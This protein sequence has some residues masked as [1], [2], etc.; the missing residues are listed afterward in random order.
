M[1]KLLVMLSILLAI[2]CK[3]EPKEAVGPPIGQ[4]PTS[5]NG[6]SK[7]V[8]PPEEW[9]RKHYEENLR[10]VSDTGRV[11]F[12]LN[13]RRA[14]HPGILLRVENFPIY[15]E[16]TLFH[17]EQYAVSKVYLDDVNDYASSER[18]YLFEQRNYKISAEELE[19]L[20]ALANELN[21]WE[22]KSDREEI[23]DGSNWEL[24]ILMNGKYH[25]VTSNSVNPAIK[26]IGKEMMALARLNLPKEEIY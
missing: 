22:E 17:V 5:E 4:S 15:I 26:R 14:H 21:I 7:D 1:K 13:W 25:L 23:I 12:R 24:E 20:K 8:L 9:L 19:R 10:E 2:G 6:T 18:P 16:D 11:V 3:N